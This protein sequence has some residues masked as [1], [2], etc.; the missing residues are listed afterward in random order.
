MSDDG[1][2]K[3]DGIDRERK[4]TRRKRQQEEQNN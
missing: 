3:D 2:G 1:V 4:E